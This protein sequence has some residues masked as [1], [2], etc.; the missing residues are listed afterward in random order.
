M[1][2]PEEGSGFLFFY[3]SMSALGR[4]LLLHLFSH[5]FERFFQVATVINFVAAE[6]NKRDT[7]VAAEK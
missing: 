6:G 4:L 3:V 5:F 7:S 1:S 2:Q